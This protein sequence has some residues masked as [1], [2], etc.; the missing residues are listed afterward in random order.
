[1]ANLL[2]KGMMTADGGA[3]TYAH[4]SDSFISVS[5]NQVQTPISSNMNVGNGL[6]QVY[7]NSC[8]GNTIIT[9]NANGIDSGFSVTILPGATGTFPFVG[10]PTAL[11][12]S[13][14]VNYKIDTSTSSPNSYLVIASLCIDY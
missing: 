1:M 8:T 9:L 12:S 14:L 10:G 2:A 5:E 4:I 13:D 7:Y 6:I 3:I 11:N